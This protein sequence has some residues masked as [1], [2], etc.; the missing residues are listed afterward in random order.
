MS[1][2]YPGRDVRLAIGYMS[3]EFRGEIKPRARNFL[4]LQYIEN[5]YSLWVG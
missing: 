1:L 2:E 5:V 4:K 3:L